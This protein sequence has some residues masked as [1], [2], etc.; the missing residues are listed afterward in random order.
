M[1]A[2]PH[3]LRPPQRVGAFVLAGVQSPVLTVSRIV[4]GYGMMGGHADGFGVGGRVGKNAEVSR[5]TSRA[6]PFVCTRRSIC[7]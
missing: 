1:S 2:Q 3:I 5:T 7:R 4:T 6:M